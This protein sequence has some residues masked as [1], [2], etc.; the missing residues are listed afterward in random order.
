MEICKYWIIGGE[1]ERVGSWKKLQ[2]NGR[3]R[4]NDEGGSNPFQINFGATKDT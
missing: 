4:H 2:I 3:V 1:G